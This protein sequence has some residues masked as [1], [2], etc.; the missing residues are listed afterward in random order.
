MNN[1][2]PYFDFAELIAK[3]L[4]DELTVPEQRELEQWLNASVHNQELFEKLTDETLINQQLEVFSAAEHDKAW[5]K[6]AGSTGFK[7]TTITPFKL[8]QLFPYAAAVVLLLTVGIGLNRYILKKTTNKPLALHK[9]DI[10][11]GSNKA[12]LTLANGSKIILND[13]EN[14]KIARQQNIVINKTQTGELIYNVDGS[15]KTARQPKLADIIAMNT[16]TTPR[17]G[18]YEVVLPDGTKVWLNAASSLRYPT[19]FPGN[20]RRVELTGEAYFE[21]AKNAAQPFF[22]KTTNQ[23]VEVL[24]THFNINSYSDEV[25]TKTTLLEGRVNVTNT[26]GMLLVKLKPGQQAIGTING[27]KV[28][29]DVDVEEAIAWK[30]GKFMFKNTDLPT[31]MRLL[32]RWYDVDVEYQGTIAEKHYM[33]RISRHVPVSQVFE[34]LKTSGVNFTIIGRKIIVKP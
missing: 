10:L 28:N 17:G 23:T 27:M 2:Q 18:Q 33:G 11:P 34:I 22:V 19:S 24:G 9:P 16:L 30:N 7:K 31:I 14:G 8:K 29:T 1:Y 12:V 21:V 25:S 5:E 32:S 15:F 4:R 26:S 20:E 3:Y 13:A 6:I